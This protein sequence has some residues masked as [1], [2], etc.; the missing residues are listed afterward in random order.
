[1]LL[2]LSFC[3]CS[4]KLDENTKTSNDDAVDI[5]ED[6]NE[7][8]NETNSTKFTYIQG[9]IIN[10]S[11]LEPIP[12]ANVTIQE[13]YDYWPEGPVYTY[14][15][16]TMT[17]S[18]GYFKINLDDRIIKDMNSH[19]NQHWK[20]HYIKIRTTCKN[21]R[22][23]DYF[24]KSNITNYSISLNPICD[25][26]IKGNITG[27]TAVLFEHGMEEN[28]VRTNYFGESADSASITYNDVIY[29][30]YALV[31]SKSGYESTRIDFIQ[32]N[33]GCKLIN[34]TLIPIVS[35]ITIDGYAHMYKKEPGSDLFIFVMKSNKIIGITMTNSTGNFS[36]S[37]NETGHYRFKCRMISPEVSYSGVT[38]IDIS[39]G[40][41]YINMT[42][43]M[44]MP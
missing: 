8:L 34:V 30:N 19:P 29:G 26:I 18:N 4:D 31:I 13:F 6:S 27:F 12:F 15:N 25:I 1:M 16:S 11:N 33:Q 24:Y 41:N 28:Y 9:W 21:Y 23:S 2:V 35:N 39:N 38:D 7:H 37:A 42:I 22:P 20:G 44:S 36:Y 3:G 14:Y 40:R 17:D 43:G 10:S 5:D 32:I